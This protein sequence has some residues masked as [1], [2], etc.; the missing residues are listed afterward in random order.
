[1]YR[2]LALLLSSA[3]L[4]SVVFMFPMSAQGKA[5]TRAAQE[6]SHCVSVTSQNNWKGTI[7]AIVNLLRN[8][9]DV[10][11]RSQF[12]EQLHESRHIADHDRAQISSSALNA[13]EF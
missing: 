5:P 13:L 12:A 4:L 7:C 8:M 1:M 2:L 11:L 9:Q 10:R 6:G 3:L